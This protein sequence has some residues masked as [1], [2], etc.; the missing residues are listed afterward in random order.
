[1][2]PSLGKPDKELYT[3]LKRLMLIRVLF[4]SFLLAATL[5]LHLK[6]TQASVSGSLF[7][8]Y[9]LIS[10]NFTLSLLY[11]LFL[12]HI[13]RLHL[14]TYWQ[15]SF[16]TFTVTLIIYLTGGFWSVFSF[17]FLVVIIYAS[18][19]LYRKGGLVMAGLCSAQ[20][21]ILVVMQY[22]GLVVPYSVENSTSLLHMDFSTILFKVLITVVACFAVAFLSGLLAEQTRKT[23]IEL[24]ALSLHLKRVEKMA[25]MGEMAAG[26]AHEIKNPLASLAGCIQLL[27]DEIQYSPDQDRLMRI[28]L[29]ETDRLSALVN[30][31]LLF[32]RPPDGKPETVHLDHALNEIISLFEKDNLVSGK[33][34]ITKTLAPDCLVHID[35]VHFRQVIWNLLLNAAE[36]IDGAG[37]IDVRVSARSNSL[38]VLSIEDSGPGIPPEHIQA[39]FDP[40]FT[41]KPNGTGLGLSIVHRI[42][43]AY[44]GRLD[45]QPQNKGT[46][47]I[48]TLRRSLP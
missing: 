48:V 12:K 27:K 34:H 7:I 10:G 45:I 24:N 6:N 20:Y 44:D 29:R 43:E 4:T 15:V 23:K 5:L 32:A 16:D 1:M 11:T 28:V 14:F 13:N 47:V 22:T 2:D 17:L 31:F 25:S 30:N 21:G 19:L 9:V 18:I 35:P 42:L 39:I 33:V 37:E 38:L 8:L 40:F 3:R 36:A 26:L 41:T 46:R